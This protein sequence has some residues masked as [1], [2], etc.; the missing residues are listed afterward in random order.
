VGRRLSCE[1]RHSLT[2]QSS[3]HIFVFVVM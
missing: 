3:K 2:A 1:I